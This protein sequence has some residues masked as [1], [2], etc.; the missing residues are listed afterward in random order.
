MEYQKIDF[1]DIITLPKN[2]DQLI[3][4]VKMKIDKLKNTNN[5]DNIEI[6]NKL[7]L[8]LNWFEN[9]EMQLINLDND[10]YYRLGYHLD[11]N[12]MIYNI[13]IWKP[14][15]DNVDMLD[16]IYMSNSELDLDNDDDTIICE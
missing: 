4:N 11:G 12:L 9:T 16:R 10:E 15:L 13:Q 2:K 6:A 5:M 1:D 7:A 14:F 3:K 8:A